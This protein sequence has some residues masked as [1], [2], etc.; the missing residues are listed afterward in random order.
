MT[1]EEFDDTYKDV[2]EHVLKEYIKI[3]QSKHV[4]LEEYIAQLQG[5]LLSFSKSEVK[6]G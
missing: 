5:K 3:M 4:V 6:Q 1:Q 2:D